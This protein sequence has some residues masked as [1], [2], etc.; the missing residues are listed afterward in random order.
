[1][2]FRFA[3][4]MQ[5]VNKQK[6]GGLQ[7]HNE[8]EYENN[9]NKDIDPSRTH[10]NHK[11]IRSKSVDEI[12]KYIDENKTS[13]RAT[14]KDAVLVNEWIISD[15]AL[16]DESGEY[17]LDES[18]EKQYYLKGLSE[19]E[20][21][22][23]F[24]TCA[25]Y[26]KEKFGFDNLTHAIVH[27]DEVN[28]HMHIGVIPLKDG[29]LSSK[30]VFNRQTLREVQQELPELLQ[31]Q[32]FDI[33]RGMEGNKRTKYSDKDYKELQDE[34]KILQQEI[35]QLKAELLR[36]QQQNKYL[37]L[38]NQEMLDETLDEFM[39]RKGKTITKH[40][41]ASETYKKAAKLSGKHVKQS[42]NQVQ[43]REILTP[44]KGGGYDLSN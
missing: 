3:G 34:K 21:D 28:P 13:K 19:K 25:V 43:N 31:R 12:L 10:L 6:L 20:R 16:Q 30:D 5:K 39:R 35:A 11:I 24:T 36:S 40:N 38:I 23:Y 33:S 15:M 1:M 22:R 41:I 17:V 42:Q 32:G 14:R 29:K 9:T 4:T 37:K 2:E 44:K 27:N 7:K 8:R 18:G 26:F